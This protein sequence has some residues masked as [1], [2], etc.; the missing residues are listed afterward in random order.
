MNQS[1]FQAITS[2][3]HKAREK[4]RG[5]GAIVFGFACIWFTNWREFF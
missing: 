5:H 1:E 4:S 3:S 2:N